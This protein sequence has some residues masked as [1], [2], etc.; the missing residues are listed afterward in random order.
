MYKNIDYPKGTRTVCRLYFGSFV[1]D[2]YG[3]GMCKDTS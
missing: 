2:K 3:Y 1:Y